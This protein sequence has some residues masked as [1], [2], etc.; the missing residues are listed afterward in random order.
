MTDETQAVPE[1]PVDVTPET[2]QDDSGK[3]HPAWD[4]LLNEIPEAWHSKIAPHLQNA[5]RN[6][7]QQLEKYTPFKEY[8][9]QGI[10]PDLISGGLNLARAIESNPKEVFDSLKAYLAENGLLEE[11]AAQAA[12]DIMENE[13]GDSID[14]IFDDVPKALKK[15]LDEL[16]QFKTQQE[17]RQY[18]QELEKAT[19][20]YTRELETEMASLRANYQISEAHEVAMYDLMNAALNAG[21]EI[22]L[23]DAAK[24]LQSM[25]GAFLPVG[26]SPSS[27]AP[28]IMGSSGGAG[29][30]APDLSIPKDD[31]GKREMLAKMFADYNKGQ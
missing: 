30:P 4:G 18:E 6:F 5:D 17:Q 12:A 29:I 31:K 21:R 1:Q 3:V 20:D 26:A 24:H 8:V 7:Q 11:E 14:D 10:A 19:Q 9:E 16:K 28:V 13:S 27:P 2:P 25:V 15:E 23:A 22:T